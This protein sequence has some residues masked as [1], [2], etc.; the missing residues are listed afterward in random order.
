MIGTY[1]YFKKIRAPVWQGN[2]SMV[3]KDQCT[4]RHQTDH[5]LDKCFAIMRSKGISKSCT[6][7]DRSGQ[8][9]NVTPHFEAHIFLFKMA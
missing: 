4:L 8:I 9:Y 3:S 2:A 6:D 1:M 7:L 5:S